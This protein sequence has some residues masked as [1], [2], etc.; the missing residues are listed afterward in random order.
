[1]KI[2][3]DLPLTPDDAKKLSKALPGGDNLN[4]LLN[5]LALDA[6]QEYLD[7]FLGRFVP[8]SLRELSE[9]RLF[10]LT[11]GSFQDRLPDEQSI[12]DVFQITV[13]R[14]RGLL[15]LV[16]ARYR[17]ELDKALWSS[18]LV[19]LDKA[20]T[21]EN[22]QV[23]IA[24]SSTIYDALRRRLRQLETPKVQYGRITVSAGRPG[25]YR[26]SEAARE[27]LKED[28]KAYAKEP[29]EPGKQAN[30]NGQ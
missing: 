27:A 10:H 8:S 2:A 17:Y 21:I 28:L 24:T 26:M 14:A 5:R 30:V 9:Y 19:A 15:N 13:G 16:A 12:S 6:T 4:D 11:T 18:A 7:L 25:T 29:G 22:D 1:M 23:E 20:T 3:F